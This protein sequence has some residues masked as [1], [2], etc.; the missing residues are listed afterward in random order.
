VGDDCWVCALLKPRAPSDGTAM[1]VTQTTMTGTKGAY[2]MAGLWALWH[3]LVATGCPHCA[4]QMSDCCRW[5]C[6]VWGMVCGLFEAPN[7]GRE[8]RVVV[9]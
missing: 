8:V 7:P 5:A 3:V 6:G 1:A 2:R 4:T 9:V